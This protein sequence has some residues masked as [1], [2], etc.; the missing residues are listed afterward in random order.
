MKI[1]IITFHWGTNYGGVLQAFALQEYLKRHIKESEVFM[2]NYAPVT[3]SESIIKCLFTKQ[4]HKIPSNLVTYFKEKK[5]VDFRRKY[6]STTSRYK[7]NQDLKE[8]PPKFDV[9]ICGSDQIW[10]PYIIETYG[11]PYYLNFGSGSIKRISYAVSFGCIEYPA[12]KLDIIAEYIKKFNHLSVRENTG[13]D[14]LKSRGFLDVNLVPDPTFL[15]D[16]DQL[17]SITQQVTDKNLLE[18]GYVFC[19][20]LQSNQ[21]LIKQITDLF[22]TDGNLLVDTKMFKYS[23]IGIEEWLGF[24]HSSTFVITNSFHGVVFSIL[25][26]RPFIVLPIE[27]ALS[28]MNDRINT[29]LKKFD[30][31]DRLVSSYDENTIKLL[32]DKKIDW[33]KID[34]VKNEL[35][36]TGTKYLMHSLFS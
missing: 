11:I 34:V 10:N 27:G 13:V 6:L 7:T 5:F 2:I 32:K 21:R 28:G 3:H 36:A 30:M 24:I 17:L 19:Y 15:F 9:Y 33:D 23:F 20:S 18:N 12:D 8:N 16:G 35:K 29:L 25:M 14:I 1:G 4:I 31:E 26:K 22:K